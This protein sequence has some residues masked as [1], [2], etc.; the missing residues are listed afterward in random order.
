MAELTLTARQA[1][2]GKSAVH[3]GCELRTTPQRSIAS[4]ARR[5]SGSTQALSS[6]LQSAH[7]LE[8]PAPGAFTVNASLLVIW[9]GL[10]QWLAFGDMQTHPRLHDDLQASIGEHADITEQ[11]DAWATVAIS[12][13]HSRAVLERVCALDLGPQAFPP[14]SAAR[15]TMEHLNVII[16]CVETSPTFVLASASSSAQSFWHALETALGSVCGP[17]N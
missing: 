12:G 2:Q 14:G 6:A 17:P 1:L 16:A 13:E 15:T 3:T 10:N 5:R 8:L 7:E 4:I 11:T 9:A